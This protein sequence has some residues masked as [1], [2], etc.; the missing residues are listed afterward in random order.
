MG[1]SASGPAEAEVLGVTVP[2]CSSED[3]RAMKRAAGRGQ[4]LIDLEDLDIAEA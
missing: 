3:L 4:D 1:V 2:V